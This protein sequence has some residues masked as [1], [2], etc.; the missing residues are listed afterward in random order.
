[1]RVTLKEYFK[2]NFNVPN[3]LTLIRMLMIPLYLILFSNGM[4]YPAL[5]IFLAASLTD[6]LDGLIARMYHQI[7]NLGK[8]LDPLA[9]KLMI[10]TVMFSMAIGNAAIPPVVPWAAVCILLGK[11]FLLMLGGLLMLRRNIVV[12]S[13]FIGKAAHCLFIAGLTATFFHD[14]L[15]ARFSGWPMTPDLILLWTAVVCTLCALGFYVAD[16]IRKLNRSGANP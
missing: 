10:L 12:Y 1:M 8:L 2:Q 7:T 3:T 13:Y 4:K 14:W 5:I 6:L 11:E 16:S 15:A 9:D